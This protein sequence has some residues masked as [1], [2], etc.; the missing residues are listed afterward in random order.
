[1]AKGSLN[2]VVL[3]DHPLILAGLR[4]I[5][6]RN[7]LINKT[8]TFEQPEEF[9]NYIATNKVD[10]AIIDIRIFKSDV[11]LDMAKYVVVKKPNTKVL[12][13]SGNVNISYITECLMIGVNGFISKDSPIKELGKAIEV[14]HNGGT[15]N[16]NDVNEIINLHSIMAEP[17]SIEKLKENILTRRE[18]E[19]LKLVCK[20]LED[21][22]IAEI[23]NISLL[24]V[25]THRNKILVKTKTHNFRELYLYAIR[26]R[27]YVEVND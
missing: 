20:G 19:V 14:I 13:Y 16:S 26:N 3:D 25:R 4:D 5:F 7:P 12:I 21:K 2:I 8:T 23:L 9:K 15:Y 18:L 27:L 17:I 1:M 10:I 11:G 6:K 24:T 22:E